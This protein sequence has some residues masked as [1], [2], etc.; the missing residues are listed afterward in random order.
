MKITD[1]FKRK[2]TEYREVEAGI[3]FKWKNEYYMATEEIFD[4]YNSI[5]LDSGEYR[6]FDDDTMVEVLEAELIVK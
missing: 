6:Y 1:K 2:E 3:V 4:T 5:N